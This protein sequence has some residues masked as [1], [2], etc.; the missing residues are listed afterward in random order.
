MLVFTL[1]CTCLLVYH[2]WVIISNG[3]VCSVITSVYGVLEGLVEVYWLDYKINKV[4]DKVVDILYQEYLTTTNKEVNN[5]QSKLLRQAISCFVLNLSFHVNVGHREMSVTLKEQSY[6]KS[7][8]YNGVEVGR[9]VSYSYTK[10]FIEWLDKVG[11][12]HL[13]KG[14]VSRWE[15]VV[16]GGVRPVAFEGSKVI[17]NDNLFSLMSCVVQDRIVTPT[18]PSVLAIRDSKGNYITKKLRKTEKKLVDLLNR[19]NYNSRKFFVESRGGCYDIQIKK[20]F[21]NSS[22]ERGGR[23]YVVGRGAEV[24]AKTFREEI[25]IDGEPTVELDFKSLHPNIL[26]CK[27]GIKLPEDFDHYGI[28]M[29][30][31]DKAVLRKICKVLLLCAFNANSMESAIGATIGE[32]I[33]QTDDN[34]VSLITSWK[35]KGLVPQVIEF[36]RI[37][38][39]LCEHNSYADEYFFS[40]IGLELQNIDSRI[41]DAI[42]ELFLEKGEFVLPIH[43]SILI[44]ERLKDFGVECM[45][46][47]YHHV[48]GTLDN[49]KIEQK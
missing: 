18:I 13:V 2:Y 26:A 43:D 24:M 25:T 1:I 48:L 38:E 17:I 21:N 15:D 7:P 30:G 28:E 29:E 39:K 47:A 12:V 46:L 20:V 33:V 36:K 22:W 4:L 5:H 6:S 44:A 8:I 32:F 49:C 35:E 37:A 3:A 34:D 14:E 41:I 10:Q 31:Y 9:K 45:K 27:M 40:G 11:Y 42:I 16:G 23:S 19:H